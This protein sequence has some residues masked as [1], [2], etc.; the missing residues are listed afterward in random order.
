[1]NE[2]VAGWRINFRENPFACPEFP[3]AMLAGGRDS[4]DVEEEEEVNELNESEEELSEA[5]SVGDGEGDDGHDAEEEARLT[6]EGRVLNLCHAIGGF[7]REPAAGDSDDGPKKWTYVLGDECLDC[8]RDLKRLLR[9]HDAVDDKPLFR[10]L[11]RQRVIN[12]LIAILTYHPT[13]ERI[14]AAVVELL[15]PMTWPVTV[16]SEHAPEMLEILRTYKEAFA[17]PGP[18]GA[19]FAMMVRIMGVP[20]AER[21]PRD[22]GILKFILLLITNLLSIKDPQASVRSTTENFLRSNLQDELITRLDEEHILEF[23]VTLAGSLV[24]MRFSEWNV[25]L[26]NIFCLVFQDRDPADILALSKNGGSKSSS[27][28]SVNRTAQPPFKTSRHSR[29]G[30]AFTIKLGDGRPVNVFQQSAAFVPTEVLLDKGKKEKPQRAPVVL[31]SESVKKKA[32]S[33]TNAILRT[34]ADSILESALNPFMASVKRDFDIESAKVRD[35]DVIQ[36]FDLCSFFLQYQLLGY[37]T[38]RQGTSPWRFDPNCCPQDPDADAYN[39]EGIASVMNLRMLIFVTRKMQLFHDEKQWSNLNAALL[40]FKD[41]LVSLEK[42]ETLEDEQ[43]H[44]VSESLQHNLFYESARM[45]L[46]ERMCKGFKPNVNGRSYLVRLIET[47]HI[48]L[49]ML[50]RFSKKKRHLFVRSS[51]AI[52]KKKK[53]DGMDEGSEHANAS[54]ADSGAEKQKYREVEFDFQKVEQKFASQST[55]ATYCFLLKEYANL[56]PDLLHCITRM[57]YRISVK[58]SFDALF[59]QLSTLKLFSAIVANRRQLPP[60]DHSKELMQLIQHITRRF[61]AGISSNYLLGMEVRLR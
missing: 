10:F 51:R 40:C 37:S 50:E 30:G 9:K 43:L 18:Y 19:L 12:D 49:R 6:L 25:D 61:V 38:V 4:D 22:S 11:G 7:E 41:M 47:V 60:G 20:S 1:M 28:G 44:E 8:L 46:I 55:I 39:F 21:T 36:F 54:D 29:F 31:E 35:Q 26:L 56:R 53:Q 45:D 52:A 59:F 17:K 42:M 32:S 48:F 57:F 5:E 14:C 15:V 3:L 13:K 24:D 16:E 23:L 58:Q 27:A 34:L 33:K 2:L